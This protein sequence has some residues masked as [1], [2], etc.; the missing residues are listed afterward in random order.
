MLIGRSVRLLPLALLCVTA[1][2][3][4]PPGSFAMLGFETLRPLKGMSNCG[5]RAGELSIAV[6][7]WSGRPSR[8][9]K[10]GLS[11]PVLVP[12]RYVPE[13]LT[14][15][16]ITLHVN[17]QSLLNSVEARVFAGCRRDGFERIFNGVA[18]KFGAPFM[19]IRD[20][21]SL[22]RWN[23]ADGYVSLLHRDDQCIMEYRT[24]AFHEETERWL[25]AERR[26]QLVRPAGL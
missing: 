2:A 22:A 26:K 5:V 6:A 19:V 16:Q 15:S 14:P 20:A 24:A 1:F 17:K 12:A 13:W 4:P 21:A 9:A 11:G 23:G 3:E 7:C 18:A 8:T 10:G 25:A